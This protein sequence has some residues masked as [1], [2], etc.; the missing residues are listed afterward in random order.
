MTHS[1]PTGRSSEQFGMAAG[2][3]RRREVDNRGGPGEQRDGV[4]AHRDAEGA[5]ADQQADVAAD[6]RAAGLV[7]APGDDAA[8]R[9]LDGGQVN[10]AHEAGA[11]DDGHSI[12]I[13]LA[14]QAAARVAAGLERAAPGAHGGSPKAITPRDS[15]LEENTSD[16]PSLQTKS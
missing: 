1:V 9:R 13:H 2:R 15:R 6:R 10:A 11:A 14:L 3:R 16:L 5:L 4:V 12:G 7:A 8:L